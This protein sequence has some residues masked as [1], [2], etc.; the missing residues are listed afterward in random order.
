MN[1]P[2]AFSSIC[3]AA[4]SQVELVIVLIGAIAAVPALQM[5]SALATKADGDVPDEFDVVLD[6]NEDDEPHAPNAKGATAARSTTNPRRLTSISLTP[7]HH[8]EVAHARPPR[9]SRTRHSGWHP[10][11]R[12]PACLDSIR[13][14][15]PCNRRTV[16]AH[17]F[18]REERVQSGCRRFFRI[19]RNRRSAATSPRPPTASRWALL[20]AE[21][22]ATAAC[23]IASMPILC[24]LAVWSS[25]GRAPRNASTTR[26]ISPQDCQL[27][28]AL[29]THFAC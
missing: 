9:S 27:G 15:G 18:S 8:R 17:S 4:V 24:I 1:A 25:S 26:K 14:A 20:V 3:C 13:E 10:N 6:G 21:R 11:T 19:C 7:R 16:R 2:P 12:L 28:E 5:A 22:A 23:R 29:A